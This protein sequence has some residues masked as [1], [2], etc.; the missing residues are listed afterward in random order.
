MLRLI[1]ITRRLG[2]FALRDLNL[3]VSDGEYYVLLGRSGSGK[4]QLLELLPA[5]NTLT[6]VKF[7]LMIQILPDNE[8]RTGK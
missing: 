4:T 6:A 5:L 2:D 1:N 3:E 8:F 7:S